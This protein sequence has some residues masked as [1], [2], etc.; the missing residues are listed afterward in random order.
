MIVSVN[1]PIEYLYRCNVE[2]LTI[3]RTH[4]F[5]CCHNFIYSALIFTLYKIYTQI[6]E[7]I[8]VSKEVKASA[9]TPALRHVYVYVCE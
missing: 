7:H 5:Q 8:N 4:Y 9:N 3:Q 2:K 1:L 6:F